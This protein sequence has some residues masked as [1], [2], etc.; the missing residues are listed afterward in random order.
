M[1]PDL[2]S[3]LSIYSRI[4]LHVFIVYC[5]LVGFLSVLLYRTVLYVY[6]CVSV[7]V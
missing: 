4:F 1:E 2:L 5:L 3:V 6:V 7:L